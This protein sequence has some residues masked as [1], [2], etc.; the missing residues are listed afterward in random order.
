MKERLAS[1]KRALDFVVERKIATDPIGVNNAT[2]DSI[3]LTVGALTFTPAAI[4]V[5]TSGNIES[6]NGGIATMGL[7][8]LGVMEWFRYGMNTDVR[9]REDQEMWAEVTNL[10]RVNQP[11]VI[12]PE[13][14]EQNGSVPL[15]ESVLVPNS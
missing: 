2:I 13:I 4:D 3:N 11:P 9:K 7:L 6:G 14:A 1:A 10:Y 5:L 8:T 12:E 15:R